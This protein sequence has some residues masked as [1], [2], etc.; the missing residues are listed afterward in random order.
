M[1]FATE[2]RWD[3]GQG[4]D[5]DGVGDAGVD[6][7]AAFDGA[8]AGVATGVGDG[9]VGAGAGAGGD[10]KGVEDNAATGIGISLG[11]SVGTAQA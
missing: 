9:C 8:G 4:F 2:A 10:M 7:F 5:V 3:R 11:I 6:V 1:E